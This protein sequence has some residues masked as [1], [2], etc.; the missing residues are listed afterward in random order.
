MA[1]R[2]TTHTQ[3]CRYCHQDFV[4]T[5]RGTQ[6][7]CSASCRT[8]YCRKKKQGTL[9]QLTK[10]PGPGGR[11]P[12]F[13]RLTMAAAAGSLAANTA[14]QTLEYF[15]ITQ[16]LVQQVTALRHAQ[17]QQQQ[18]LADL[19]HGQHLLLQALG[20]SEPLPPAPAPVAPT[21]ATSPPPLD[22]AMLADLAQTYL[23][24]ALADVLP[25]RLWSQLP[26]LDWGGRVSVDTE[27]R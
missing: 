20:V 26:P 18:V 16:D 9:H 17:I 1:T 13:A 7:Y 11:Q 19:R 27:L 6:H 22:A 15:A 5:R 8:S 14:T 12:S 24:P 4:P 3:S 2:L 25:Q 10:L 23:S 21:A